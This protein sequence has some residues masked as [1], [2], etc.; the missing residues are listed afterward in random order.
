MGLDDRGSD[1]RKHQPS[2]PGHQGSIPARVSTWRTRFPAGRANRTRRA[3]RRTGPNQSNAN[4]QRRTAMKLR[5]RPA[6]PRRFFLPHSGRPQIRHESFVVARRTPKR[7]KASGSVLI[8]VL[9]VAFGLVS[10][11][12]YF[13]HS[14][15]LELRAAD[16]RVA[17][18][19]AEQAIAG[20]ARYVS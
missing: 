3:D 9:W 8:I 12:L 17:G 5:L 2:T 10:L 15:S 18:A 16:N 19:E 1:D 6:V 13:A 14:M 7:A 11:T 20:A 4:S